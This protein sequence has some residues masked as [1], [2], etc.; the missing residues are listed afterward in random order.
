MNPDKMLRNTEP[1]IAN[2]CKLLMKVKG[3]LNKFNLQY[4]TLMEKLAQGFSV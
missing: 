3:H 4:L 2:V 1:G